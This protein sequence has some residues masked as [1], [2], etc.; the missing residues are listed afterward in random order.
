MDAAF[1]LGRAAL[2]VAA[3]A[4]AT[5]PS[6]GRPA[7]TGST[8]TCASAAARRPGVREQIA[9]PPEVLAAW[10]SGFRPEKPIAALVPDDVGGRGRRVPG[11]GRTHV[12]AVTPT[13][14]PILTCLVGNSGLC[15]GRTTVDG[16]PP[17][18]RQMSDQWVSTPARSTAGAESDPHTGSRATPIYQTTAYQ[19]RDSDH[20]ANL[21]AWG[22]RSATSTPGS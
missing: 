4:P 14:S 12:L 13:G 19:F 9:G 18:R 6:C 7:R 17:S 5:W 2:W 20:S 1:S 21:F 16:R 8:R 10:L 3:L 15:C 22:P 11:D